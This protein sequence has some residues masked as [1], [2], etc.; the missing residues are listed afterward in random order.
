MI[1]QITPDR[2]ADI[3]PL[4]QEFH[5]AAEIPG[6]FHSDAWVARWS[7][8]LEEGFGVVLCQQGEEGQPV[9]MIGGLIAP[10]PCDGVLVMQEA[11]WYVDP[12][13]RGV[14]MKLL[15]A[16]MSVSKA[17]GAGRI[18]VAHTHK[19]KPRALNRIYRRMGFKPFETMY[20]KELV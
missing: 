16:F 17:L 12:G 13:A 1:A 4:C 6:E 3:V 19:L 20:A 18:L 2:L 9:G 7:E 11:F 14:G 8:F 15:D 10:D 5:V